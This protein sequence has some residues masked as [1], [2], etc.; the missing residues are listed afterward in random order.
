MSLVSAEMPAPTFCTFDGTA[1]E[2]RVEGVGRA[3][4]IEPEP[5]K[6]GHAA[7]VFLPGATI[8]PGWSNPRIDRPAALIPLGLNSKGEELDVSY[9]AGTPLVV[10]VSKGGENGGYQGPLRSGAGCP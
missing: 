5:F 3:V 2:V 6:D 9:T 8:V 4:L 7:S 10:R 1:T